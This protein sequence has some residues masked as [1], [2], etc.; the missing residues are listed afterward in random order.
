M[1]TGLDSLF[2]IETAS[3]GETRDAGRRLALVLKGGDVLALEGD[4]G[5]GKT[6]LVK[7][8]VDGLG[9]DGDAVSSPTFAIAQQYEVNS[10]VML[11]VDAYRIEDEREFIEMG[12]EDSMDDALLVA[13][14]WP[15]QMGCLLPRQAIHIFIRHLGGDRRR[16]SLVPHA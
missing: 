2:P 15:S 3:A 11:H 4:L 10:G 14:E 13:V 6:Q 12:M 16:I 7:G 1:G 8:L 5:S 9:G